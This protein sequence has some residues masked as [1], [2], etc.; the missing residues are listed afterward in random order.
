VRGRYLPPSRSIVSSVIFI[1]AAIIFILCRSYKAQAVPTKIKSY[2]TISYMIGVGENM[3][4][5]AA[6]VTYLLPL[7]V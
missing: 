4:S 3:L 7:G 1:V 2:K 5:G 6:V